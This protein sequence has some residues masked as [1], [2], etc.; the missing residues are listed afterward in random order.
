[1]SITQSIFLEGGLLERFRN[2]RAGIVHEHVEPAESRDRLFDR[3]LDRFDVGSV[4]LD[5]DG[6]SALELNRF[7]HGGSRFG[8]LRI[9]DGHARSIRCQTLRDRPADAPGTAGNE[10]HLI[11]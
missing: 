5:R 4:R 1:M 9:R 6:L 2:R 8:V 10:R 7:D 3:G 11:D